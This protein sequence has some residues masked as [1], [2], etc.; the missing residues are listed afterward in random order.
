MRVAVGFRAHLEAAAILSFPPDS[1]LQASSLSHDL[2]MAVSISVDAGRGLPDVRARAMAVLSSVS[3]SLRAMSA[4]LNELMPPTVAHVAIAV[5]TAFMAAVVDA[6]GWLD[7][8]LVRGFVRGFPVVGD[9]P[10]S[11]VYRPI[12]RVSPTLHDAALALF[13]SST[14]AWNRRLH[15]RLSARALSGPA[16]DAADRAVSVATAKERSQSLAVGPFGS[17]AAVHDA[18]STRWPLLPRSSTLPRVMER[19]G[20]IQKDKVRAIDNARSNGANA[21][22]SMA[23]TITTP[24]FIFPA[25]VARAVAAAVLSRAFSRRT[26]LL[27]SAMTV[28]LAD[29][30]AAYRLIPT[31][32]PW[33]TAFGF[34]DPLASPPRPQYHYLPGNAFGLV[35]AV[36][37]FNRFPELVVVVARVFGAVMAEHY[38]DDFIVPDLTVGDGTALEV[39]ETVVSLLGSGAPWDP[40]APLRSSALD[41]S[42]TQPT[43][44]SNT[45][46]GVVT[47]LS[48]AHLGSVSF[49]V[50]ASRVEVVM[51]SFHAAFLRGVLTPHE[52]SQLRGKLFFLLSAAY[53]MIG[54]AASLPLVQRQY[55]DSTH[56]FVDGSELHHSYLFYSALLPRLP[57]LVLPIV[58]DPRPPL[59]IYTDASFWREKRPRADEC[60]DRRHGLRG[61]LGAVLYDPD[62][63]SVRSAAASPP[64]DLLLSSWRTDRKTYIAELEMLAAISV[65]STYPSVIAG[66]RVLHFVDNTVALSALVHGYAGKVD[67]AKGVNV[68]YLQALG[69]RTSVYFDYVPSKANIADLPSRGAGAEL[70][71]ELTGLRRLGSLPWDPL[72]V[73][74]VGSWTAPLTSWVR[75]AERSSA[76][77]GASLPV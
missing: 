21:A 26:S 18:I 29:L 48:N 70:A 54:R 11:G 40:S 49:Y 34:F 12:G 66:R 69:L 73:P 1:R 31:A 19:F 30:K 71:A 53:G 60:G 52:A 41:P 8:H 35:S 16:N 55:R 65:Y 13:R 56:E 28:A 2:A 22:T 9:I 63:G 39:V 59:I 47:D 15:V 46:L 64:W 7:K 14:P 27:L 76:R 43:A 3:S 50:N 68:F 44:P 62:D 58:P 42:K 32:Q 72:I 6:T 5:N 20:V 37:N 61:D 74:S 36:V 25:V 23:E 75:S 45:V 67:L 4:R 33:F 24:H 17:V 57:R 51:D 77:V 10:D 38:F